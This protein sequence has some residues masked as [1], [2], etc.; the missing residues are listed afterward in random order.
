M[1]TFEGVLVQYTYYPGTVHV[2][3]ST[4]YSTVVRVHTY[5]YERTSTSSAIVVYTQD[6]AHVL[7]LVQAVVQVHGVHVVQRVQVNRQ[8]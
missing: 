5:M 4:G 3:C 2:M 8:K 6:C 1:C 7:V